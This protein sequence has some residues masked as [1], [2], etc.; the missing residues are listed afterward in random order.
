MPRQ[1][2]PVPLAIQ[3]LFA[4][5]SSSWFRFPAFFR[6][7]RFSGLSRLLKLVLVDVVGY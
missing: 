1:C 2:Q 6:F 5:R 4:S 3:F 7:F